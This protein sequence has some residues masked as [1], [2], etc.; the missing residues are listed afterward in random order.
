MNFKLDEIN[1]SDLLTAGGGLWIFWEYIKK[2]RR[3]RQPI[4]RLELLKERTAGVPILRISA[5]D[6]MAQKIQISLKIGAINYKEYKDIKIPII[7]ANSHVNEK[8]N[9][10]KPFYTQSLKVDKETPI[11]EV[12]FYSEN[13]IDFYVA[14]IYMFEGNIFL[15][16]PE[17]QYI[18]YCY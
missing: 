6:Y 15:G 4:I 3:L 7:P 16:K 2:K 10:F 11:G 9:G 17:Y 14:N 12:R 8:I 18:D 13:L 5:I 1:I